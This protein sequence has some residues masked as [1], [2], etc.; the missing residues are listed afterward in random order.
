MEAA[1]KEKGATA[2]VVAPHLGVLR[3]TSSDALRIDKS[4]ATVASVMYDALYVPNGKESLDQLQGDDEARQFVRE[5]YNHGKAIAVGPDGVDL[6]KSVGISSAPGVV[7]G[8][9]GGDVSNLF[10]EAIGQHRH[11]NRP[12]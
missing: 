3:G 9:S 5:A 4:L 2:E 12:K 10:V 6:L 11:W 1:L 7:V 8:K